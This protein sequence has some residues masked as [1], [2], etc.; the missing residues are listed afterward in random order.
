M[1]SSVRSIA[2]PP[3][4][5]LAKRGIQGNATVVRSVLVTLTVGLMLLLLILPL[6]LVF[7]AAFRNG[8]GAWLQTLL[9][10]HTISAIKLTALA[11]AFA[12]PL[13]AA[14][15]LAAAWVLTRHDLP[16]RSAI[17]TLI[18]LPFSVSPVVSG[19]M[20]ILIFG[21]HSALGIWLIEHGVRV[22]FAVPGII[23]ATIFITFPFVARE[24]I[25]VME[26]IGRDE[27]LAAVSLGAKGWAVLGRITLP[28]IRWGLLYG[29]ILCTARAVGEF[30]A[31]SVVSGHIRGRTNTLPLHIEVLFNEYQTTAAFSVASLLTLF[32]LITLIVKEVVSRHIQVQGKEEKEVSE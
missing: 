29:I 19:L 6:L 23:I 32:A 12:V 1:R 26:S 28:N 27:E 3:G 21:A 14:F 15:G 18:D 7:I 31:V 25:P 4:G 30:G 9:H 24:L 22:V 5:G 16:C 2:S 8:V 17:L 11:V 10:P 20:F 13:N